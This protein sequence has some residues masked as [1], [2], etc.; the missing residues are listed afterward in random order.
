MQN[1]E[2]KNMF[3]MCI[4]VARLAPTLCPIS[5]AWHACGLMFCGYWPPIDAPIPF[6]SLSASAASIASRADTFLD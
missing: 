3:V 1:V 4:C 6:S 5:Y 2:L